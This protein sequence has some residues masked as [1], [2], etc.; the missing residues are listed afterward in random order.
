M[1]KRQIILFFLLSIFVLVLVSCNRD[2]GKVILEIND[3]KVYEYEYKAYRESLKNLPGDM[4]LERLIKKNVLYL[5]A[6]NLELDKT[7]KL[8]KRFAAFEKNVNYQLFFEEEIK[9]KLIVTEEDIK[10]EF[11]ANKY[12][13][14]Q[15][16]YDNLKVFFKKKVTQKKEQELIFAYSE[17]LRTK[18]KIDITEK[19]LSD[20]EFK[21]HKNSSIVVALIG[22]EIKVTTNEIAAEIRYLQGVD[23]Y[24]KE[25]E[26]ERKKILDVVI[27]RK[28]FYLESTKRDYSKTK[29]Y[30][31]RVLKMKKNE[32]FRFMVMK[33]IPSQLEITESDLRERYEKNKKRFFSPEKVHVR[34]ILFDKEPEAK[35]INKKIKSSKTPVETFKVYAEKFARGPES[36][37]KVAGDLGFIQRGVMPDSFDD[38]AFSL[39]KN[40]IS[41]IVKTEFGFHI[42]LLE[43]RQEERYIPFKKVKQKLMREIFNKQKDTIVDDYYNDLKSNYTIR[44]YLTEEQINGKEEKI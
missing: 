18:Y 32:L 25:S 15:P 3:F 7:P 43:D 33:Y 13:F 30:K 37:K 24:F 14:N 42:I 6:I 39:G 4:V 8:A 26:A 11:E 36:L 31:R 40:E 17:K 5:E 20:K 19:Y 27:N 16:N 1:K 35:K 44:I 34:H 9:S 38:V 29:E 21:K 2:K 41:Q 22:E 12:R 28:I 23:K 10:A